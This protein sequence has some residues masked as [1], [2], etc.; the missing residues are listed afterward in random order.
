MNLLFEQR[1]LLLFDVFGS[2]VSV[3]LAIVS[4]AY[5]SDVVGAAIVYGADVFVGY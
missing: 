4:G 1:S 3:V 5:C 2:E